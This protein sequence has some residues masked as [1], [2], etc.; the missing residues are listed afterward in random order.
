MKESDATRL[1]CNQ[2]EKVGA[3]TWANVMGH[4]VSHIPDRGLSCWLGA[5]MIEFKGK[6]T[7]LRP[8]QKLWMVDSNKRYPNNVILRYQQDL[9]F[10]MQ[11]PEDE[12]TV[13]VVNLYE[14]RTALEI[15]FNEIAQRRAAQLKAVSAR[16]IAV[17]A[18]LEFKVLKATT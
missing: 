1:A 13:A 8:G 10:A 9:L 2:F 7:A 15:M 18:C 16:G 5:C 3:K 11:W 14:A 12:E 17:N 6:R 4:M